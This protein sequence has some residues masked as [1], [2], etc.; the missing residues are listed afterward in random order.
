MHFY[1]NYSYILYV[2]I[3]LYIANEMPSC[4]TCF[5]FLEHIQASRL[6]GGVVVC[7]ITINQGSRLIKHSTQISV[8]V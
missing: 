2:N 7:P 5:N 1:T 4:I 3:C 6:G 8:L